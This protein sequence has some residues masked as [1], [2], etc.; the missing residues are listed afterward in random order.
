MS[1][2]IDGAMRF[3]MF[4]HADQ[5]YGDKPYWSHPVAVMNSL[6]DGADDDVY[7]AA[8]LHDVVEDTDISI[9]DIDSRFGREVADM[10]AALSRP[11]IP[12]MDWIRDI[13]ESGNRWVMEIKLA[14]NACNLRSRPEM[15]NRYGKSMEILEKALKD[16]G[17]R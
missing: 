3:I 15:I 1:K 13:A 16:I 8:L 14:D 12:Y 17:A 10:V 11:N 4:A 9:D 7:V 2:K 6:P 5:N